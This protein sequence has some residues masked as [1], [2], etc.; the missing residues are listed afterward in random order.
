MYL[1]KR[2]QR[3]LQFQYLP[4]E[5][6]EKIIY[7]SGIDDWN[8]LCRILRVPTTPSKNC[9]YWNTNTPTTNECAV[10]ERIWGIYQ[11]SRKRPTNPLHL[12]ISRA[13]PKHIQMEGFF[14]REFEFQERK[15]VKKNC[16]THIY[17]L[18]LLSRFSAPEASWNREEEIVSWVFTIEPIY[19]Y[20][21]RIKGFPGHLPVESNELFRYSPR[22][23]RLACGY[24]FRNEYELFGRD[25]WFRNILPYP[26]PKLPIGFGK[27]RRHLPCMRHSTHFEIDNIEPDE[28]TY[29]RNGIFDFEP[30]V[31]VPILAGRDSQSHKVIMSE[32]ILSNGLAVP[33][34]KLPSCKRNKYLSKCLSMMDTSLPEYI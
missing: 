21:R 9:S 30:I 25:S 10:Y 29:Y 18:K 11:H 26:L 13:K 5:L 6:C 16:G 24:M 3:F 19:Y 15:I 32:F 17:R 7:F 31:S 14:Q 20:A 22:G 23:G 34:V 4:F 12:L 1:K 33:G 28:L 27:R 8:V 2:H